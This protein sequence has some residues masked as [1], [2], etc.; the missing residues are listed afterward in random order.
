VL[1]LD[2]AGK[3]SILLGLTGA[4]APFAPQPNEGFNVVCL[5]TAKVPMSFWESKLTYTSS[6][7]ILVFIVSECIKLL[8]YDT[9]ESLI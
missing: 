5:T 6:N 4:T 1:G 9:T 3:S 8:L 7:V 2:G